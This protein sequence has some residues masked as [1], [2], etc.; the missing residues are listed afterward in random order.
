MFEP[1]PELTV[2]LRVSCVQ[3]ERLDPRPED[4]PERPIT[5]AVSKHKYL[6]KAFCEERVAHLNEYYNQL[7]K[8]WCPPTS[9]PDDSLPDLL[10]R[11][12]LPP[13]PTH[14][15]VTGH[16][17]VSH[18]VS[19][20]AFFHIRTSVLEYWRSKAPQQSKPE[21]DTGMDKSEPSSSNVVERLSEVRR[22]GVA[23]VLRAHQFW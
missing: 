5:T 7:L 2:T 4:L 11:G 3:F 21:D 17:T 20:L 16:E 23:G 9:A 18:H 22:E 12:V 13:P 6:S 1:G 15:V 8:C 19:F 14:S 10:S